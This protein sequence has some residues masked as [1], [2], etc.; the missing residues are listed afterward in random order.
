MAPSS[1]CR[2]G[3]P[4]VGQAQP[5][6]AR[7]VSCSQ[8]SLRAF[9][10]MVGAVSCAAWG[11]RCMRHMFS[12]WQMPS[13]RWT[14]RCTHPCQCGC[15]HLKRCLQCMCSSACLLQALLPTKSCILTSV[16]QGDPGHQ[17]NSPNP[18]CAPQAPRRQFSANKGGSRSKDLFGTLPPRN[19]NVQKVH[20]PTRG[21]FSHGQIRCS[22]MPR[23]VNLMSARQPGEF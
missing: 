20:W 8:A 9:F 19:E 10:G 1:A 11:A 12:H 14:Q 7:K 23:L 18:C 5:V 6:G 21:A 2:S 22:L 4:C 15:K 17:I 16:C 13:C 3:S